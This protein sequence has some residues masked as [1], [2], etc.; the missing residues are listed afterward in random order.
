VARTE[1]GPCERAAR[2]LPRCPERAGARVADAFRYLPHCASIGTTCRVPVDRLVVPENVTRLTPAIAGPSSHPRCC[3]PRSAMRC[4]SS[5]HLES[6]AEDTPVCSSEQGTPPY[7]TWSRLGIGA[8]GH[9]ALWCLLP[10]LA[11]HDRDVESA[12]PYQGVPR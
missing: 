12:F 5:E 6:G 3:T 4:R 9:T 2:S 11:A 10:L 1:I 8:D 7:S